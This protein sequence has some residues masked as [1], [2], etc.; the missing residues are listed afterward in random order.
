MSGSIRSSSRLGWTF[1]IINSGVG[2]GKEW[3][4]SKP[5]LIFTLHVPLVVA[6]DH[7]DARRTPLSADSPCPADVAAEAAPTYAGNAPAARFAVRWG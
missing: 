2:C 1:S 4:I 3:T 6:P 5:T 7:A